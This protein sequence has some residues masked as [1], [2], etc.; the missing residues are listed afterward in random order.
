MAITAT[1]KLYTE[2]QILRAEIQAGNNN[3]D[4]RKKLRAIVFQLI[5]NRRIPKAQGFQ[6]FI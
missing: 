3:P 6:Y 5:N 1:E 2:F 4:L